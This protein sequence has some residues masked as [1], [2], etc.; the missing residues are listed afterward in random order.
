M[1]YDIHFLKNKIQSHFRWLSTF[2][3]KKEQ[4]KSIT[5][6]HAIGSMD[7][8]EQN[9]LHYFVNF[10]KQ[11]VRVKSLNIFYKHIVR[12]Q[13]F[14]QFKFERYQ[15]GDREQTKFKIKLITRALPCRINFKK[16]KIKITRYT[17]I[18][19]TRFT[20]NLRDNFCQNTTIQ[21][22]KRKPA[23]HERQERCKS[24]VWSILAHVD[25]RD[26]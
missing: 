22:Q 23:I 26:K 15:C 8:L 17:F 4:I 18:F 1:K 24:C 7:Q 21:I 25:A 10:W 14:I 2:S 5:T 6:L 12:V 13:S 11:I 3:I 19:K 9:R 20:F 16:S